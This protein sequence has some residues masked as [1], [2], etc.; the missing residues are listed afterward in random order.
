MNPLRLR[1][2]ALRYSAG[3]ALFA[4]RDEYASF[5]RPLPAHSGEPISNE[6]IRGFATPVHE[7]LSRR[8]VAIIA[9]QW[10][11]R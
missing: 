2:A 3:R 9:P 8:T 5:M 1:L 11:S 10:E 7:G 6:T 4:F